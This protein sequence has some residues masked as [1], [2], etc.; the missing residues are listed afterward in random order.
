MRQSVVAG[1]LLAAATGLLILISDPLS[2]DVEQF[3]L[4]GVLLGAVLGLMKDITVWDR[5]AGFAIGLAAAWV[6]YGVRA[7]FL[8]DSSV[9]RAVAL[10]GLVLFLVLVVWL[11]GGRLD[12]APMLLGVAALAG[13]YELT[14]IEAPPR[15]FQESPVALTGVLLAAAVGFACTVLAAT[16]IRPDRLPGR[17]RDRDGGDGGEETE[18]EV[19]FDEMFRRDQE[20]RP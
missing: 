8:P 6:S 3:A 19:P 4:V 12:L 11:A 5:L 18:A 2:L 13:A 14:F 20:V 9:G 10:V 1:L 17:H 7:G 16:L 15:F